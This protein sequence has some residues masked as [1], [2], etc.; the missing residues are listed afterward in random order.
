MKGGNFSVFTNFNFNNC[1]GYIIGS[2]LCLIG[3]FIKFQTAN[4]NEDD[5]FNGVITKIDSKNGTSCDRT[6]ELRLDR[7]GAHRSNFYNCVLHVKYGVNNDKIGEIT[8]DNS[9]NDYHINQLIKI[10]LDKYNNI[11]IYDSFQKYYWCIFVIIGFL[12]ILYS[13]YNCGQHRIRSPS[14]FYDPYY[15]SPIPYYDSSIVI[16]N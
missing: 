7:Y 13:Y 10:S 14:V 3:I 2:I 8:I 1:T 5:I 6:S 11:K 12:I 4:T 9:N 15:S 16:S